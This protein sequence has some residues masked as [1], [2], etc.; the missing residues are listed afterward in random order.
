MN[1]HTFW[2]GKYLVGLHLSQEHIHRERWGFFGTLWGRCITMSGGDSTWSKK[3]NKSSHSLK[4]LLICDF[5]GVKLF[6]WF[7]SN[8]KS[9]INFT[10]GSHTC[11]STLCFY[12][13]ASIT[14]ISMVWEWKL[15]NWQVQGATQVLLSW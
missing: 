7:Y 13:W 8:Q 11:M 4:I 12:A 14:M 2:I 3:K 6:E 10:I 15:Q 5:Q 1:P 9:F